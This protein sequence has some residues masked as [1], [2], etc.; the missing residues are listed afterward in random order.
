[1]QPQLLVQPQHAIH[2]EEAVQ[3]VQSVQSLQFVQ[4][5]SHTKSVNYVHSPEPDNPNPKPDNINL[6]NLQASDKHNPRL[7]KDSNS[8]KAMANPK[9]PLVRQPKSSL[10]QNF[11]SPMLFSRSKS[12]NISSLKD[13]SEIRDSTKSSSSLS[14][15]MIYETILLPVEFKQGKAKTG[16]DVYKENKDIKNYLNF[17]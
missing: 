4:S 6:D 2:Q 10:H 7:D 11:N 15:S 1:M 17:I 14:K 16:A 12:S 13:G 9:E 3:S 8:L 5:G